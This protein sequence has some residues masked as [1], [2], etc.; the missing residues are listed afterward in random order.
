MENRGAQALVDGDG[1]VLLDFEAALR[2]GAAEELSPPEWLRLAEVASGHRIDAGGVARLT[3]QEWLERFEPF[4]QGHPV[5]LAHTFSR[6]ATVA[7]H[8]EH[9]AALEALLQWGAA[10]WHL[11]QL[12][13][14]ATPED[15]RRWNRVNSHIRAWRFAPAARPWLGA[16]ELVLDPLTPQTREEIMTA[17][18]S[19]A[20]TRSRGP[21]IDFLA[22]YPESASLSLGYV[23]R[24]IRSDA[25]RRVRFLAGCDDTL[26]VWLNSTEIYQLPELGNAVPDYATIDATLAPG[27]NELLVEVGQSGGAWGLYFRIEDEDGTRLHLDD[28][29]R[30]QRLE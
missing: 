15:R 21:F 2:P 5:I 12:G 11:E 17:A 6:E 10:S 8:R 16:N 22:A 7:W 23:L 27:D 3:S 30:L 20:V 1:A 19:A 14:A 9:A 29:G 18:K 28:E 13:A 4:S 26:R 24:T 25:S